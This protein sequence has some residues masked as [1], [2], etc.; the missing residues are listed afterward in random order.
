MSASS[1]SS[2]VPPMTD[3]STDSEHLCWMK[4]AMAMVTTS[5]LLTA[6]WLSHRFRQKRP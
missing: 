4:E 3:T 5:T 1:E 2:Q 6:A